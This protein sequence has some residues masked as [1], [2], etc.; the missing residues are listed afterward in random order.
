[1]PD[2]RVRR[3]D[4]AHRGEVAALDRGEEAARDGEGIRLGLHAARAEVERRGALRRRAQHVD[5]VLRVEVLLEPQELP[6]GDLHPVGIPVVVELPR[7]VPAARL[8]VERDPVPVGRE[9]VRAE[10]QPVGE[11][12]EHVLRVRRHVRA[13]ERAR[14]RPVADHGVDEVGVVLGDDALD[15]ALGER[16]DPVEHESLVLGFAHAASLPR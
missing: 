8:H 15:V 12:L 11:H 6:A 10:V 13:I 14:E 1:V 2:D 7:D 5:R 16:V 3:I 9:L 4:L